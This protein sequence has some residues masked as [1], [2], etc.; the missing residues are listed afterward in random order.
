MCI[1]D[2]PYTEGGKGYTD[3]NFF[4]VYD[5]QQQIYTDI[6]K[7]LGEAATALNAAGKIETGDILYGGAVA[8]WKKFAYSLLLRAGM[9]L[10]KADAAKA[11]STVQAAFAAGVITD[12]ADNAYMRHDANYAQPY[13]GTLNSTEAANFYLTKPFV[14]QLK[15]T[16]A[17]SYT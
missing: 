11:Q 9:R 5:A 1:R 3:Q 13:G 6:I 16:S 17:V 2:R 4:P 10:S 7:E 14:D 15:N 12:N 8:Q